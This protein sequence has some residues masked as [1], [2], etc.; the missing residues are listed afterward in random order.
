MT[1]V[2]TYDPDGVSY[3]PVCKTM[4]HCHNIGGITFGSDPYL[5]FRHD[6][7]GTE[8]RY[9]IND[10]GRIEY[11]IPRLMTMREMMGEDNWYAQKEKEHVQEYAMEMLAMLKTIVSGFSST[12]RIEELVRRATYERPSD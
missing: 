3:C 9:H 10:N 1:L 11:P 6:E 2:S 8:W 12:D 7:C 4:V 5:D